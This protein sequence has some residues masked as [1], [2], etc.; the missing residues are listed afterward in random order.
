MPKSEEETLEYTVPFGM[1]DHLANRQVE[2]EFGAATHVGLRR[3]E[4]EDHFAVVRRTRSRK[5]LLTNV[6]TSGLSLPQD[7]TYVLIVADGIGGAGYGEVASELIL[8]I[9]WELASAEPAWVMKLQDGGWLQLREHVTHFAGRMQQELRSHAEADPRLAGMG[10][11]WTCAYLMGSDGLLAHV[12]DSRAYQFR[13]GSLKQLTRDHTFARE[14]E[15]CGVSPE[16]AAPF[17]HVLTNAFG[18]HDEE[19]RID[20]DQLTLQDR[21]RLLLC[22]DGL[23]NMVSDAQITSVL[24]ERLS[25]A[26][27]CDRLVALALKG[28]GKD[29]VTV[30]LADVIVSGG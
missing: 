5:I 19:V 11:T 14:L 17:Q 18:A 29:N 24:G 10:T 12:G 4:N 6:N 3:T 15:D 26:M 20:V 23:Y 9:G 2:F 28:G 30:V 27:T 16:E 7:D 1:R 25:P 21:D 8:R 13:Q 22:S